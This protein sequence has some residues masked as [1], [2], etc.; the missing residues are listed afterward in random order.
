MDVCTYVYLF[1]FPHPHE[2]SFVHYY[3]I[4]KGHIETVLN[5][6]AGKLW[7]R[8]SICQFETR[9]KRVYKEVVKTFPNGLYRRQTAEKQHSWPPR[10]PTMV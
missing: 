7:F 10:L 3:V 9:V 4:N 5:F 6:W 2:Q 1:V 8:Q